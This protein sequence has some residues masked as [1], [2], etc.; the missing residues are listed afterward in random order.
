MEELKN[1]HEEER[2]KIQ[3]EIA[4]INTQFKDK[5]NE[6][7]FKEEQ[8]KKEKEDAK[9]QKEIEIKEMEK[10][11][12]LEIEKE[13]NKQE[14]EIL[15]MK[16]NHEINMR[17]LELNNN[18]KLIKIEAVKKLNNLSGKD[19]LSLLGIK[20]NNNINNYNN[21]QPQMM[22]QNI[23][24]VAQHV[25]PGFNQPPIHF[26]ENKNPQMPF[27]YQ[28][29]YNNYA[30]QVP[31]NYNPQIQQNFQQQQMNYKPQMIENNNQMLQYNQQPIF[32]QIPI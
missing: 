2:E 18:E 13:K 14:Q 25:T 27:G 31:Q 23:P 4:I 19:F 24:N 10:N 28:Q 12:K 32:N 29:Q 15:N 8:L 21:V 7:H 11:S 16:Q 5:E 3:K 17:K 30:N 26:N 20:D 6:W 9:N 1:K 22:N